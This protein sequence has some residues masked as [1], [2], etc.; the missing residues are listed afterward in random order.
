[1]ATGALALSEDPGAVLELDLG[2]EAQQFFRRRIGVA[3]TGIA[4]GVT[5]I[6]IGAY[7]LTVLW[8]ARATPELVVA[9][10]LVVLGS[11]LVV[12]SLRN[13]L[14]NPTVSIRADARG[15]L[16]TRRWQRPVL[17][18]WG[19][20]GLFLQVEDLGPDP[21]SSP[22]EKQHLF[23]MGP[24]PVYGTLSPSDLGPL[25][26]VVR[27]RE[28]TVQMKVIEQRTGRTVHQ[29]R[30]VRILRVPAG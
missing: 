12:L 15:L 6:G 23:F 20:P 29:V 10:L 26:D 8:R 28:L 9:A 7:L 13:G 27:A 18:T 24:G 22:E 30:R 3:A 16:F 17:R 4:I 1:M 14:V 11:A 5:F 25:L 21:T 2:S 19:A